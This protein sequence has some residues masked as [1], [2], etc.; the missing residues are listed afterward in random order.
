VAV[1]AATLYTEIMTTKQRLYTYLRR[2]RYFILALTAI[3]L[4]FLFFLLAQASQL[5]EPVVTQFVIAFAL[6]YAALGFYL[7]TQLARW[8]GYRRPVFTLIGGGVF[9][10]GANFIL[11]MVMGNAIKHPV[12]GTIVT[13]ITLA[14]GFWLSGRVTRSKTPARVSPRRTWPAGRLL[15]IGAPLALFA[16]IW[17]SDY[18]YNVGLGVLI[19]QLLGILLIFLSLGPCILAFISY[20]HKVTII[21]AGITA[22]AAWTFF[23]AVLLS[24]LTAPPTSPLA[25]MPGWIAT[26]LAAAPLLTV[27]LFVRDYEKIPKK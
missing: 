20:Y 10:F 13:L 5:L 1:S 25:H 21:L 23:V 3:A 24:Y 19:T 9:A 15:A 27:G 14:L 2:F 7:S 8:L 11:S 26:I 12:I 18:I 22:P 4:V 17:L 6:P 16:G